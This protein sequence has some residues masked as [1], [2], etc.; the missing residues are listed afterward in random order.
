MVFLIVPIGRKPP[1][2][3]NAQLDFVVI[4]DTCNTICQNDQMQFDF[5]FKKKKNEIFKKLCVSRFGKVPA[6]KLTSDVSQGGEI[7]VNYGYCLDDAPPWYQ[8]LF[9]QRILDSYKQTK[10]GLPDILP[11]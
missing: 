10:T 9:T 8:Q 3:P 5:F 7:T 2:V 1:I 11:E 4:T 6:V